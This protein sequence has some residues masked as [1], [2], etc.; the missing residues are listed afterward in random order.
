MSDARTALT[1]SELM[2]IVEESENITLG[3]TYW[4]GGCIQYR[5]LSF[6][7]EVGYDA[8]LP[9]QVSSLV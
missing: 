5:Q 2:S 3:R 4:P 6:G 9:G 8:P 1:L 7:V